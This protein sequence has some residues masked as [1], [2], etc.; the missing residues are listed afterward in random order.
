MAVD[1]CKN[2]IELSNVILKDFYV[3]YLLTGTNDEMSTI[4]VQKNITKIL[5]KGGMKIRKWSS[6][7]ENVLKQIPE[8]DRESLLPL[9]I[10]MESNIKTLGLRWHL[11]KDIFTFRVQLEEYKIKLTKRIIMSDVAKIYDPIRWLEP[12]T[13]QGKILI[14]NLWLVKAAWDDKH[15]EP[16][17]DDWKKF[18]EGL[19]N[20]ERLEIP[21][22]L[23]TKN[24]CKFQIHGFCD[25]F[26]VAYAAAVYI[27]VI[28]N[29]GNV[30]VNLVTSKA[31][32]RSIK[33]FINSTPGV[34]WSRASIKIG[35]N[36]AKRM[37]LRF[38]RRFNSL[39]D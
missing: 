32:S 6:N 20:L 2:N 9:N 34:V 19:V 4:M 12:V 13:I 36:S 26:S 5:Q 23:Q 39:L 16:I 33:G 24:D 30:K 1:E 10:N 27:R 35:C 25:E 21:R 22:W 31:K 18:R 7:S 29:G 37:W 15:P 38:K 11:A 3:D 17:I 14:Q 8:D 28:D